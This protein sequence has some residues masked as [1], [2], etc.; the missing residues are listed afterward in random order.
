MAKARLLAASTEWLRDLMGVGTW[1][2]GLCHPTPRVQGLRLKNSGW[3]QSD[4][5]KAMLRWP[6]KKPPAPMG[7]MQFAI[8]TPNHM[9][10]GPA[11]AFLEAGI[12]VIC[13]KPLAATSEQAQLIDAAVRASKAYFIL[14]HLHGLSGDPAGAQL[15]GKP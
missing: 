10:A 12:H 5:T 15:G 7:L 3:T 13:D 9:H 6:C 4:L 2:P 11:I 8:V 1:W 14:T